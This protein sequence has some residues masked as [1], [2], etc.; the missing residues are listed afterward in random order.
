[1]AA[2]PRFFTKVGCVFPM[3]AVS[4]LPLVEFAPNESS[5]ITKFGSNYARGS[6]ETATIG[7]THPTLFHISHG[8]EI[9]MVYFLSHYSEI[10]DL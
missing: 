10:Y 8:I 9:D 5:E 2:F 1:M 6:I 7:K 3:V 4:I